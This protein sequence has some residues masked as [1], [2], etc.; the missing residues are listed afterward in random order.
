ML[1][2]REHSKTCPSWRKQK[3]GGEV[4]GLKS[5]PMHPNRKQSR[6]T[7]TAHTKRCTTRPKG[8]Q[9][10]KCIHKTED[11]II[12]TARHEAHRER[13]AGALARLTSWNVPGDLPMPSLSIPNTI[14]KLNA[15]MRL[16]LH[17][18]SMQ[19][20]LPLRL[21]PPTCLTAAEGGRKRRPAHS[22]HPRRLC[23]AGLRDVGGREPL[24]QELWPSSQK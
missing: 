14:S 1:L 22:P 24:F 10:K 21:S 6:P 18:Q 12:G 23:S 11:P 5:W 17:L 2:I 3:K 16:S 13:G 8:P 20:F 9:H 15:P 7:I 4:Q 19:E